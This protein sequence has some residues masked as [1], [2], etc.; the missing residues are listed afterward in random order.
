P[1][2]RPRRLAPGPRGVLRRGG[3]P[4]DPR[5]RP[6]VPARARVGFPVGPGADGPHG[7]RRRAHALGRRRA[8]RPRAAVV[9]GRPGGVPRGGPAPV[10]PRL[11]GRLDP[12]SGRAPP[13]RPRGGPDRRGRDPGAPG[14]G[15]AGPRRL[16]VVRRAR[17]DRPR[18]ARAL[19]GRAPRRQAPPVARRD[20]AG[21]G[22]EHRA[23]ARALGP[24]HRPRREAPQRAL[25]A[26][27]GVHGG[28]RAAGAADGGGPAVPGR[29]VV[30][31]RDRG[32][33]AGRLHAVVLPH[34]RDLRDRP[35]GDLGA[36]RLHPRRAAGRAPDRRPP[37]PGGR[38]AAGG[39]G[40]RGGGALGRSRAARP[41][42]GAVTGV[43]RVLSA[44]LANGRAHADAFAALVD[45]VAPDVVVVQE[46]DPGQ[47][48]A[49]ARV[50]PFG[51]L[52]PARDHHGMGIALREPGTIRRL[53]LPYRGAFVAE[54]PLAGDD[55]LEVV[56]LHLAAPHVQPL[57]RRLRERRGQL[58][59]VLAYLDVTPRRR[60]ILAGDL[61]A[62]PL[63]PA[64]RR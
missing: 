14:A 46:L 40:V 31:D 27:A 11:A 1:G 9:R 16:A 17:R 34:L 45:A 10:D 25:A 52:E 42:T 47:A 23:G 56:N 26:R 51:K 59:D 24:G 49:L 50:M 30:P 38:G 37:P 15:R 48:E 4:D 43:V 39:G 61:N 18:H 32:Q 6:G 5:A 13:G 53:P 60:R 3:V 21:A 44:N 7:R 62:T 2:L 28:P 8:G 19:H 63:W 57:P 36:G 35:A 20:A 33:A 58:R 55:T 41:R 29:A 64:Y 54:L 22:R 12:G